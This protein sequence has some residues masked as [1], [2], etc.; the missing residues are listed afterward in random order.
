MFIVSNT[1]RL[2]SQTITQIHSMPEAHEKIL[3]TN[4]IEFVKD[5]LTLSKDLQPCIN[6][7]AL[8]CLT[9]MMNIKELAMHKSLL[10]SETVNNAMVIYFAYNH[11][12]ELDECIITFLY[13]ISKYPDYQ[14]FMKDKSKVLYL[15]M[16]RQ[17]DKQHEATQD[18]SRQKI[19]SLF[20]NMTENEEICQQLNAKQFVNLTNKML[21]QSNINKYSAD[22]I[23]ELA[24]KSIINMCKTTTESLEEANLKE[25]LG[26]ICKMYHKFKNLSKQYAL[27]LITILTKQW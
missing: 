18:T 26:S 10:C 7:D 2:M 13:T 14:G 5:A 4:A 22:H 24:L 15:L 12:V 20:H 17:F 25:F 23:H 6:I 16:E 21:Q 11:Q 19:F 27:R 9:N 3:K 8:F 1:L